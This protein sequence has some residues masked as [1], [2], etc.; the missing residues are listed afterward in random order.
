MCVFRTD[1]SEISLNQAGRPVLFLNSGLRVHSFAQRPGRGTWLL[2]DMQP[3]EW[4][5][6]VTSRLQGGLCSQ[7]ATLVCECKSLECFWL[8]PQECLKAVIVD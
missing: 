8:G 3:V 4:F 6:V 5:K 2:M 1:I 7:W